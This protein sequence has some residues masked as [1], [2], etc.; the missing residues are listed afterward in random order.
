MLYFLSFEEQLFLKAGEILQALLKL[1]LE[2]SPRWSGSKFLSSSFFILS[3]VQ[4]FSPFP[5]LP[6][7]PSS[8]FLYLQSIHLPPFLTHFVHSPF[9]CYFYLLPMISPAQPPTTTPAKGW[10]S[11]FKDQTK[12]LEVLWGY[13]FTLLRLHTREPRIQRLYS[14][15]KSN[16]NF[17]TSEAW[18]RN[19]R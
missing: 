8:F 5:H 13:C 7:P 10:V 11:W 9:L 15:K 17:A 19:V 6:L 3:S 2:L 12:G 4:P 18:P 1:E 16:S 14:P